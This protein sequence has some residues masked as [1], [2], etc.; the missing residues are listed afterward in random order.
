MKTRI[1]PYYLSL[2]QALSLNW[3]RSAG[4]IGAMIML[5][6]FT[7][8]VEKGNTSR[9]VHFETESPYEVKTKATNPFLNANLAAQSAMMACTD[10]PSLSFDGAVYNASKSTGAAGEV[11]AVYDFTDVTGDGS[12]DATIEIVAN[13]N[14]RL[15][16]LDQTTTGTAPN[17]QPQIASNSTGIGTIAYIDFEFTFFQAGS[18]ILQSFI[19]FTTSGVD[20]DGNNG[21]LREYVGFQNLESF[22]VEATNNLTTDFQ[23]IYFTFESTTPLQIFNIDPTNTSNLVYTT[24]ETVSQFRVRAGIFDADFTGGGI[25][26]RQFSFNFD[27]CLVNNFTTPITTDV[28][29]LEVNKTVSDASPNAGASIAYTVT[30]NNLDDNVTANGIFLTDQLP[31]GVTFSSASTSQGTFN[32]GTDVWDVGNIAPLGSATLTLNVTV[33]SGTEGNTVTNTASISSFQGEDRNQ[34][35]NS[36]SA[37]FTVFDPGGSSCQDP[38]E[39]IFQGNTLETGTALTEGA[40]YRFGGVASG[41][42]AL[43]TIDDITGVSFTNIDDDGTGLVQAFQPRL[44]L[45]TGSSSG[46]VDFTIEFVQTGTN[47]PVVIDNFAVSATDIDGNDATLRD[48][49]GFSSLQTYTLEAL[50]NVVQSTSGDFDVFQSTTAT[51]ISAGDERAATDN[52]VYVTYANVSSFRVRAGTTDPT[53]QSTS[54]RRIPFDFTECIID[55]FTTPV[56]TQRTADLTINKT[57]NNPNPIEGDTVQFVITLDNLGAEDATNI[58]VKDSLPS[59]I[60]LI[61]GIVGQGT[62]NPT[63]GIWEVGDLAESDPALTLTLNYRVEEVQADTTLTNIVFVQ[64]FN[65]LDPTPA[66]DS[67]QVNVTVDNIPDADLEVT[68]TIQSTPVAPGDTATFDIKIR[69]LGPLEAN[70]VF[71]KDSLT[72]ALTFGSA[73]PTQGSFTSGTGI[74]DVGTIQADDSASITLKYVGGLGD[75]GTNF[76][77]IQS[78]DK[79]DKV[80]SNDTASVAFSFESFISGTIFE[81]ITG[82]ELI[83]GDSVFTD[84]SGDQ[85][86][87]ANVEVHLYQDGGNSTLDA[88]ETFVETQVTDAQGNYS[89]N[90]STN[91]TYWVVVD[92]K[93][94][95]LTDGSYWGEQTYGPVGAICADGTGGQA[96]I[97]TVAG[98]CYAGRRGDQSDDIPGTPVNGSIDDAEHL[99]QITINDDARSDVDFGFSFNVVTNTDDTDEDGSATRFAQGTYRQFQLNA[100][101]LSAIDNA[102]RFV[103]AVAANQTSASG[104]WWQVS[105]NSNGVA[106]TDGGTTI[107]GTAYSLTSP[108]TVLDTNTGQVGTGGTVGVD[109]LAFAQFD[110]K[111]FEIDINDEGTS[112]L[113]LNSTEG[114]F[115]V[116]NIAIFDGDRSI[117]IGVSPNTTIENNIIGA[118]ADGADPSTPT[119]RQDGIRMDGNA[120]TSGIVIQDNYIAFNPQR[121][122]RSVNDEITGSSILRNE[123]AGNGFGNNGAEGVELSG[124]WTI[125]ENLIYNSG[126]STSN[127]NTGGTGIEI[128]RDNESTAAG[129]TISNNTIRDNAVSGI[130]AFD[131]VVNLTIEKNIISGNG[132]NT[133]LDPGDALAGSGIQLNNQDNDKDLVGVTITQNSIFENDGVGIDIIREADS[134]GG[135]P[136][137]VTPNDGIISTDFTTNPNGAVDY[138]VFTS[139]SIS[140]TDLTVVGYVGTSGSPIAQ[141]FDIELFLA[142]NTRADNNGEIEAGDA[143]SIAHGEGETFIGTVQSASDG[144]FNVTIALPSEIGIPLNELLTA[145]ATATT[146]PAANSTSEFSANVTIISG[147]G[148]IRGFVYADQDRDGV[149]GTDETGITGVTVVLYNPSGP[150]CVSVQTDSDGAYEFTGILTGNYQIIESAGE[151]VPIPG[152]CPPAEADPTGT[153]S[154]TPNTID[155]II[156]GALILDQNFGDFQGSRI[157]GIVFQDTGDGAGTANDAVQ[158]GG[159]TGIEKAVIQVLDASDNVIQALETNADGT[160]TFWLTNTEAPDASSITIKEVDL[161]GFISTGGG[162]GT[163][164]GTYDRTV[165]EV[166]FTIS[167]GT[168][169]TGISFADVPVNRLLTDGE[170]FAKPGVSV[171][172][173][174]QF[175]ANS[176]GTVTF[177]FTDTPN[178]TTSTWTT[179]LYEDVNCNGAIDAGTDNVINTPRAFTAGQSICLIVKT[180][181]PLGVPDNGSNA[182]VL[183]A[184]FE[185]DNASPV[186]QATYSRNDL[187]R[188]GD[189]NEAGLIIE[190]TVDK[191]SAL[192]GENLTY[193]ITY[194]NNGNTPISDVEIIDSTPAYTSFAAASCGALVNNLTNCTITSP[195][196]GAT[197]AVKWV[198]S[199]NLEP[200]QTSTVQYTVTI[201]S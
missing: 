90:I 80:S 189:E 138:P 17:F 51:N 153:V 50:S 49:A 155:I 180:T 6:G 77:F 132:A 106:L 190:K 141:V 52:L 120:A 175:D 161:T 27:P 170:Q 57:V 168:T 154:T 66:N 83:D 160:F 92:S 7:R 152:T 127:T 145:T 184:T 21:D 24:Y 163:T 116:R 194:T 15:V 162:V 104:N 41:L 148:A 58:T 54:N 64:N 79:L 126:N 172:F 72:T 67:A 199:G 197:G 117:R 124:N 102:M 108:G 97:K 71:L 19:D 20:V 177:S 62:F 151:T 30:I 74:W 105:L 195:S 86:P 78:L 113:Y 5:I 158:G 100:N 37:V 111:E 137:G 110:R 32:S 18:S 3:G 84:A 101:A 131:D 143:Q 11:G 91:G 40:V 88:S 176:D 182:I 174:H 103:P 89:F 63:T 188:V 48:L 85:Q 95:D 23:D 133:T 14:A 45:L 150:S 166:S 4:F 187:V 107:D 26:E 149:K 10:L 75:S 34:S 144:T 121:G 82:D 119:N 73:T 94:G 109:E 156:E 81:D 70:T 201:D 183:N 1:T 38:P 68:K 167:A 118:R 181:V 29:D 13:N 9:A 130:R 44:Q 112:A 76:A 142:N 178:P 55:N 87:L 53:N 135:N 96:A 36:G 61:N 8:P 128:G 140:G 159:E 60:T 196:I 65:Q 39:F 185:Y 56:T 123:I 192:P 179:L 25:G 2:I 35:N 47:F 122:I 99:S 12:T 193:T 16:N 69:N 186:L 157:D 115:A 147:G 59:G 171:F 173:S 164:A 200:G 169:Y 125:Q 33:D 114:N 42:D 198:L 98:P 43:V 191:V 134:G 139:A 93:T 46:N 129:G 146:G 165:D 31:A 22:T 28:F 136:D